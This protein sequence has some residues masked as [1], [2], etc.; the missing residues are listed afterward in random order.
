MARLSHWLYLGLLQW[1]QDYSVC[2]YR[3][4]WI[5]NFRNQLKMELS[6]AGGL[7]TIAYSSHVYSIFHSVMHIK[8]MIFVVNVNCV[9]T[10]CKCCV[11]TIIFWQALKVN[12]LSHIANN[13][14]TGRQIKKKRKSVSPNQL[15]F[16]IVLIFTLFVKIFDIGMSF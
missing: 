13:N 7:K 3:K 8:I 10:H 12:S 1:L 15:N 11:W 14:F 4:H 16:D 5:R 6:L 2:C 9:F